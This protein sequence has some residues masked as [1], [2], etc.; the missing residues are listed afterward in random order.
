MN[1]AFSLCSS[2]TNLATKNANEQR[3][4][5][6][7]MCPNAPNRRNNHNYYAHQVAKMLL[8]RH[9]LRKPRFSSSE[10]APVNMHKKNIGKSKL[11]KMSKNNG[12][13]VEGD[14]MPKIGTASSSSAAAK[15]Q[16]AL[17]PFPS[18]AF[19][20]TLSN[21]SK[22]KQQISPIRQRPIGK[23]ASYDSLIG[24]SSGQLTSFHQSPT[25][26]GKSSELD[27]ESKGMRKVPSWDGG[28]AS[29]LMD[30]MPKI[31]FAKLKCK[32]KPL[33]DS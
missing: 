15:H 26:H 31:N 18:S 8:R 29:R 1:F 4:D 22:A 14:K 16:L 17:F 21:S 5:G 27:G 9:E 33:F 25:K 10:A 30:E 23:S 6:R 13:T 3:T 11:S 19:S 32:K 7:T 2:V 20:Y 12:E 24:Q 28:L